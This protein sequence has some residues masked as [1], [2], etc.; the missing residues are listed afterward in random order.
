[1]SSPCRDGGA[2]F[3]RDQLCGPGGGDGQE[4]CLLV[5]GEPSRALP[6]AT[7]HTMLLARSTYNL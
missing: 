2:R 5:R 6:E 4:A 1:M 7:H 3:L